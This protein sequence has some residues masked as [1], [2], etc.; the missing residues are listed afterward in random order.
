[1]LTCLLTRVE[2]CAQSP[3]A[4]FLSWSKLPNVNFCFVLNKAQSLLSSSLHGSRRVAVKA[5]TSCDR[6]PGFPAVDVCQQHL[7]PTVT[8]N[9]SDAFSVLVG[10]GAGQ[11][12]IW[13]KLGARGMGS[14]S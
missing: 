14:F 2:E 9:A 10:Q 5:A 8:G 11:E 13:G 4:T 6:H 12:N 3:K 7:Y 1:M